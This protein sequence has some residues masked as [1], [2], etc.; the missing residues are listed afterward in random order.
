MSNAI[1]PATPEDLVA[2]A[3][4]TL[5]RLSSTLDLADSGDPHAWET[6]ASLLRTLIS[7][8]KGNGVCRRLERDF[9]YAFPSVVV[10]PAPSE[11]AGTVLAFGNLP[12]YR[13]AKIDPNPNGPRRE[14]GFFS[15]LDL[16]SIRI[17]VAA[18]RTT[19][20]YARLV[21][22]VANTTG[23]HV[24]HTVPDLLDRARV[25]G[26][27]GMALSAFLIRQVAWAVERS[28]EIALSAAG[29]GVADHRTT[30]PLHIGESTVAYAELG[31]DFGNFEFVFHV[32]PA[33]LLSL[34]YGSIS[35]IWVDKS[36]SLRIASDKNLITEMIEGGPAEI[37]RL[38]W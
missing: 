23:S 10:S 38:R 6:L 7:D 15:W 33:E 32:T 34:D 35:R 27:S 18:Q 29:L 24:S 28:C 4:S 13:A 31:N 12:D 36:G 5:H 16:K 2:G 8:G 21:T 30:R 14:V 20:S 9:G 17:P 37:A 22:A 3:R 19:F 1:R 26:V 11:P 25:F